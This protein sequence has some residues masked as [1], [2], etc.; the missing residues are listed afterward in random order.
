MEHNK[1]LI[2]A[3]FRQAKM[4]Q[5][6][7]TD[8]NL[9]V[10]AVNYFS[11]HLKLIHLIFYTP[12]ITVNA[13]LHFTSRNTVTTYQLLNMILH[14]KLSLKALLVNISDRFPLC[15]FF[16]VLAWQFFPAHQPICIRVSWSH[17]LV[18]A[19][20]NLL[21]HQ[22]ARLTFIPLFFLLAASLN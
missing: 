4:W 2:Q 7:N 6:F 19:A 3:M 12:L 1:H 20:G 8:F 5:L 22:I 11:L 15:Q 14:L 18:D 13:R 16:L 10:L 9:D 21:C 17:S